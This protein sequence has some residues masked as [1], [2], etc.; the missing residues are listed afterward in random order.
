MTEVRSAL[1]KQNRHRVGYDFDILSQRLPELKSKIISKADGMKTIDF[2]DEI[3]VELLNKALLIEHYGITE[4]NLPEGYLCPGV[5]GRVDYLLYLGQLAGKSIPKGQ[6]ITLL[7]IGTGASCIYP[8]LATKMFDW[9]VVAS[10]IDGTA[11]NS[12]IKNVENNKLSHRIEIRKQENLKSYF[13]GI[14]KKEELYDFTICNPPFYKS[15]KEANSA[16]RRKNKNLDT[17]AHAKLNFSGK[18]HELWVRG[19]ELAFVQSMINESKQFSR[20]VFWFSSLISNKANLNTLVSICKK[21][22]VSDYKVIE[23]QHGKKKIHAIAWTFLDS[24]M[25]KLWSDARWR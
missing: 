21:I 5:P 19:G 12:A 4:W 9:S 7:D 11:V 18:P 3:S 25:Q 14:I 8:L 10:D 6:N 22:L 16:N 13:C 23:M 24:K 1:N 2:S 15:E 17:H 20:Q